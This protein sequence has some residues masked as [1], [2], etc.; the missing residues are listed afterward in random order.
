MIRQLFPS[1]DESDFALLLAAY[2]K[3]VNTPEAIKF[4]SFTGLPFTETQVAAWFKSHNDEGVDYFVDCSSPET[5]RGIATVRA[6]A[7][8]GFELL[9]LVVDPV[10][11]QSGIGRGLVQNILTVAGERGYRAVDVNVFADNL[12]MLRLVLGQCFIP[13]SMSYHVRYDG[14]DMVALKRY[15]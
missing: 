9:G 5:V 10:N 14:A 7:L 13:V 12:P 2:L 8:S 6:G 1:T 11:R 3:M 15:L 4:L